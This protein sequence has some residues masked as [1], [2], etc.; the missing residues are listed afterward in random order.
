MTRPTKYSGGSR[1]L[2]WALTAAVALGVVTVTDA[3]TKLPALTFVSV[4]RAA[5]FDPLAV[6]NLRPMERAFLRQAL[7]ACRLEGRVAQLGVSQAASS[8]VRTLAQQL[9]SDCRQIRDSV[10]ALARK[11][12][13]IVIP[14]EDAGEENYA[15]LTELTGAAFDREFIRIAAS[16][17]D[18]LV[19]LFEQAVSDGK[20]AD[21]R[22]LAGSQIPT[23]RGHTNRLV[24]L[25]KAL[26]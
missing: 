26:E 12:G 7:E 25:Q 23:L 24:E 3:R 17:N 22:D 6:D 5:E 11:K 1:R 15:R 14:P 2:T 18:A 9:V 19:K 10:D 4:A 8:N 21:I 16:M 20:D 13:V